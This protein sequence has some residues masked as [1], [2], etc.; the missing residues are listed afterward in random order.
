MTPYGRGQAPG[1]NMTE[2]EYDVLG[3]GFAAAEQ[4]GDGITVRGVA[5]GEGDVSKGLTGKPTRW[6]GEVLAQ[7]EGMLE[8][9]PI[10]LPDSDDPLQHV[11][12]EK[13]PNGFKAKAVPL[14]AKVGE[15]VRDRYEPGV[16]L[17]FEADINHPDAEVFIERGIAQVSPVIMR[18]LR[19]VDE[20]LY[21][22]AK[23]H[24]VRDLGLVSEG[25]IPSNEIEQGSLSAMGAMAVEALSEQFDAFQNTS[26]SEPEFDGYST[27]AWDGPTLDGTFGGDMDAANDSATLIRDGGENFSDLSL[28]VV[29]GDG[30][31][32]LNG[33][34][35]AWQ[36]ASQTDD[37]SE[38]EVQQLRSMYEDLAEQARDVGAMP[39]DMWEDVW[40]PRIDDTEA[41]TPQGVSELL[42]ARFRPP[43]DPS[44]QK[45]IKDGARTLDPREHPVA[46]DVLGIEEDSKI[47]PE[48]DAVAQALFGS[49][50]EE[51]D[52][53]DI[54][55]NAIARAALG[56]GDEDDEE[57]EADLIDISSDPIARA[58]L[59]F[60]PRPGEEE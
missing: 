28:F 26:V 50:D 6:P 31:L 54:S 46:R 5:I 10:T 40:Q 32:N 35:S 53:V 8:G 22:P 49:D 42:R 24:A 2:H 45:T 56:I 38:D 60:S 20:D 34:N 7:M 47:D 23:V 12:I 13:T 55:T 25:A 21:E 14:D 9:K 59:G 39:D 51:K 58:A 57:E 17:L 30:Q 41:N 36:L 44:R 4:V 18:D 52:T 19:Q 3:D 15:V 48:N 1:E 16:G 27:A 37:V 43:E 29:D 11:A 33:L